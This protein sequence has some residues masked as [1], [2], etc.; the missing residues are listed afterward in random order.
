V[1]V[2]DRYDY[3][4]KP[5]SVGVPHEKWGETPM[6]AVTLHEQGS[7]TDEEISAWIIERVEAEFQRVSG[8][9]IMADFPRN[10]TG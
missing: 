2:L 9:I 8:V 1:T 5:D 4:A 6:A 3:A 10:V 7:V